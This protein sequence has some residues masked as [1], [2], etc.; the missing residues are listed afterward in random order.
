MRQVEDWDV[1]MLS[2]NPGGAFQKTNVEQVWRARSAQTASA[3]LV[4]THYQPT[5]LANFKESVQLLEERG[6]PKRDERVDTPHGTIWNTDTLCLD[7]HWKTLQ[8]DDMWLFRP[9]A[10]HIMT[11]SDIYNITTNYK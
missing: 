11:R 7:Q 3:Y 9:L 10:T 2:A 1:L 5:L 8:K 4:N 6:H